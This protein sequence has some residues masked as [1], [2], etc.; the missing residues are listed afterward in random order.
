MS[1]RREQN[2][3]FLRAEQR[4][5]LLLGLAVAVGV[6]VIVWLG[7]RHPEDPL[8]QPGVAR[9]CVESYLK[10]QTGDDTAI[11]DSRA[12]VLDPEVPAPKVTCGELRRAGRLGLD[13][14]RHP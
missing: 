8:D 11:V 1:T 2:S 3:A 4:K 5:R 6:S 9:M 7:I 12:P 13:G 10:V 14:P